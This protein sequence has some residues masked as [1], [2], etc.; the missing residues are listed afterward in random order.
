MTNKRVSKKLYEELWIK[1]DDVTSFLD[2]I[3]ALESLYQGQK[4][5][6]FLEESKYREHITI[7]IQAE[8]DVIKCIRISYL[9][10]LAEQ[11]R[12]LNAQ[13]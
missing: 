6:L 2:R 8:L 5:G 7:V 1:L 3:D 10:W 12:N 13:P 11:K 9:E 4:E